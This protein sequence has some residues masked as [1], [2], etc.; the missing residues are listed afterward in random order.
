VAGKVAILCDFDGTVTV[1]EVSTS[2]L[3]RYSRRDW[4]EADRDLFAGRMTLRQAMEREFGLLRASKEEMER[5]VSEVHLRAGFRELVAAARRHR[6]PLVIVSEGLD[7][8][9]RAFLEDKGIDVEYRTNRAVFTRNGIAMKHPFSDAG[10]DRC[11]TCKKA[12][13]ALFKR[14][15]YT[16]VY[17]GDGVSDRCPAAHADLL[18]A[19]NGLLRYCRKERLRCVPYE[20]FTDVLRVL[21]GSL[22]KRPRAASR[23]PQRCSAPSPRKPGPPQPRPRP[24]RR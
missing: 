9:I 19:R 11:G 13:L 22:W 14:K 23:R 8:Y 5:F 17:I 18:F 2:L 24:R 10:C 20:D 1:E 6:A 12:Q 15:G 3:D 21:E 16:T 4:R 7:F